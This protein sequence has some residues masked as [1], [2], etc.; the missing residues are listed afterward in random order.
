MQRGGVY[1]TSNQEK[2]IVLPEHPDTSGRCIAILFK[3]SVCGQ[4]LM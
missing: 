1:T 2:G 4:V 3:S